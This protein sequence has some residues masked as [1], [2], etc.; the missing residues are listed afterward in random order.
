MDQP[1]FVKL[2]PPEVRKANEGEGIYGYFRHIDENNNRKKLQDVAVQR[3]GKKYG[4][5]LP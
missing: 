2:F 4:R 3:Y 1:M 5:N